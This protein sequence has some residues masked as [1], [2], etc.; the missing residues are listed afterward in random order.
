MAQF[1]NRP[2]KR[3]LAHACWSLWLLTAWAAA[4][5][6]PDPTRPLTSIGVA[7]G[8]MAAS[9]VV[10]PVLQSVLISPI[11]KMAIISGQTVKLHGKFGDARLIHIDET[12]VILRNG[13]TEQILKLFPEIKIRPAMQ[14]VR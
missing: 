5:T 13:K 12:E 6:I 14:S 3:I 8:E 9:A 10:G 11:R 7:S 1:V 4:Q 2:G